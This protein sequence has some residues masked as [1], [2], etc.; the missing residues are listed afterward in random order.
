MGVRGNVHRKRVEELVENFKVWREERIPGARAFQSKYDRAGITVC[1]W[2]FQSVH[3]IHASSVFDYILPLMV[4]IMLACLFSDICST[5]KYSR[6]YSAL[7]KVRSNDSI[8]YSFILMFCLSVSDND[9]L[10]KR[11]SGL[12]VRMCGVVPPRQLIEPLID[13]IFT[14]IKHSLVR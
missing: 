7:V 12:L 8:P 4:R 3:D 5:I 10:S 1:K 2:L 11:A 14:A 13:A 6:S 9:D